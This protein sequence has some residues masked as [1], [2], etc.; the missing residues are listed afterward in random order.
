MQTSLL[1]MSN[2]TTE[3]ATEQTQQV[4]RTS[5]RQ[6]RKEWQPAQTGP[7]PDT[8]DS[9]RSGALTL[10]T[11]ERDA[12]IWRLRTTECLALRTIAAQLRISDHTVSESLQRSMA[13]RTQRLAGE[14]DAWRQAQTE[15]YAAY[16]RALERTL[17]DP[18]APSR[19]VSLAVQTALR[20]ERDLADLWGLRIQTGRDALA[21]AVADVVKARVEHGRRERRAEVVDATPP[22]DQVAMGDENAKRYAQGKK[23]N[24]AGG[25]IEGHYPPPP[26]SV[27]EL[28]ECE[29]MDPVEAHEA[30]IAKG[31]LVLPTLPL[32]GRPDR[33]GRHKLVI[34]KEVRAVLE[35]RVG[36]PAVEFRKGK[37]AYRSKE[38]G[39][40]GPK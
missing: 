25:Q 26:Q 2:R 13:E 18:E 22:L 37:K 11:S 14:T 30:A 12:E 20:L 8:V 36:G 19:D 27:T 17:L 35:S 4:K 5:V 24:R 39:D 3:Q 1:S 29:V 10:S 33:P 31:D 16:R 28:L 15:R 6:R 21:E 7:A 38:G 34:G 32:D 9:G 40:E 23:T